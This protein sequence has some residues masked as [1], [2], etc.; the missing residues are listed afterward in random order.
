MHLCKDP[1]LSNGTG[2]K[3]VGLNRNAKYAGS[4]YHSSRSVFRQEDHDP[5]QSTSQPPTSNRILKMTGWWH[6]AYIYMNKYVYIHIHTYTYTLRVIPS[7]THYSDIVSDIS[8]CSIYGI[9]IPTSIW[10]SFWYIL[11]HDFI[12]HFFLTFYLAS[13]LT[14]C[15]TYILAFW[16]AFYRVQA[17]VQV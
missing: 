16:Q 2:K 8:S 14:F 6:H 13:I 1:R 3:S 11:W 4:V 17:W 7:L 9:N 15:F 10:H 12:W 5:P